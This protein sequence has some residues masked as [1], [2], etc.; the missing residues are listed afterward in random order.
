MTEL[1]MVAGQATASTGWYWVELMAK[2]GLTFWMLRISYGDHVSGR[3][4]NRQTAPVFLG[5]G[6]YRLIEGAMHWGDKGWLQV[7]GL[8]VAWAV[9]FGMWTLHFIG[10]GD[11]KFLMALFALFPSLEFL[12]VLAFGLLIIMVFVLGF[13]ALRNKPSIRGTIE[14][15]RARLLTG[16]LLPTEAELQ[17]RG[18]RYAWTFALPAMAYAWIYW[19]WPDAPAWWPW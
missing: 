8:L 2:L 11:A 5:V 3:I 13:E 4:P 16:Q 15:W 12:A 7:I 18:R 14:T 6:L 10:G 1:A 17:T 9:L 19:N